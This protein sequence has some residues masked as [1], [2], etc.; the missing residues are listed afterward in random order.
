MGFMFAALLSL[1]GRAS[2]AVSSDVTL[3]TRP[4]NKDDAASRRD[5]AIRFSKP[6]APVDPDELPD[7]RTDRVIPLD[8]LG[9]GLLDGLGS[10]T[11]LGHLQLDD[12]A[13]GMESESKLASVDRKGSRRP[14]Q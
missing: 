12:L 13:P 4:Q 7:I 1:A 5:A 6:N 9:A 10:A 11:D 8:R 3:D 14:I 2:A